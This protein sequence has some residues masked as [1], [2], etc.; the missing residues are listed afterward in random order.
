MT[1]EG[2]PPFASQL[3]PPFLASAS[4][5]T[6]SSVQSSGRASP[7]SGPS[8]RIV[9]RHQYWAVEGDC[10]GS[11][12]PKASGAS[13]VLVRRCRQRSGSASGRAPPERAKRRIGA[14]G[15]SVRRRPPFAS[16]EDLVEPSGEHLFERP[17]ELDLRQA[18][19]VRRLRERPR[20]R[21][22]RLR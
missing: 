4:K 12:W 21:D 22:G 6:R 1:G 10:P 7:P 18:G 2:A 20:R 9:L 14:S 19:L 11:P 8:D 13:Q 17:F 15:S 5:Q 3:S 16:G